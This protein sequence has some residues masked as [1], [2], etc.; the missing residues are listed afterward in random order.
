MKRTGNGGFADTGQGNILPRRCR[1]DFH[2]RA[3]WLLLS[4]PYGERFSE[5]PFE[6][7]MTLL[8]GAAKRRITEEGFIIA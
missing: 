7:R 6:A 2:E 4:T 3:P 1:N 5:E 8:I